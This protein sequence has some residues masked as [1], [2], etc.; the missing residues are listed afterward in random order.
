MVFVRNVRAGC[1]TSRP[2]NEHAGMASPSEM[3]WHKPARTSTEIEIER[4]L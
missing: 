1:M 2:S 3:C 4:P